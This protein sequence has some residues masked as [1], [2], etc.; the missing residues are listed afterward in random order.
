MR[1]CLPSDKRASLTVIISAQTN[2]IPMH[3]PTDTQ[4]QQQGSKVT[5]K[6]EIDRQGE[7]EREER[8]KCRRASRLLRE[9]T[10]KILLK[11]MYQS[12]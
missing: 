3:L 8:K 11:M 5:E 6:R 7:R 4:K 12:C 9:K 2:A 10:K 1:S